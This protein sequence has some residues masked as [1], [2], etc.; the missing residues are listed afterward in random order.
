MTRKFRGAVYR[1]SVRQT[2]SYSLTVDGTAMEGKVI[3]DTG[4]TE[5]DVA[6]TV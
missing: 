2:G 6:V 3:P 4:K 1:I 5:Y